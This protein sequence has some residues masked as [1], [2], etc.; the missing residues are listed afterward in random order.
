VTGALA[1]DGLIS[2]DA[3][4]GDVGGSSLSLAGALTNSA[5]LDIG[6]DSLSASDTVT[7]AS[8]DNT[9]G[10][11]VSVHGHSADQALLDLTAGSAGFG[12]AGVLSRD[13]AANGDSRSS[14]RTGRSARSPPV[15]T[16]GSTETT[17]SSRTAR[18][19]GRT[20]L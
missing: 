4:A 16:W 14:L 17:P 7:A 12:T 8:L 20:A 2:L 10:A 3:N 19:S 5:S 15:Q 13:V 1:N 18:R 9:D 11:T 6:N